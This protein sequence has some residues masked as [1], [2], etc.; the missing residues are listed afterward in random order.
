M[1]MLC[2]PPPPSLPSCSASLCRGQKNVPGVPTSSQQMPRRA[3]HPLG[4]RESSSGSSSACCLLC[5]FAF[6]VLPFFWGEGC[7][8]FSCFF[9]AITECTLSALPIRALLHT[10]NSQ[11]LI[12]GFRQYTRRKRKTGAI[13]FCFKKRGWVGWGGVGW[14]GVGKGLDWMGG[15]RGGEREG[16]GSGQ[17][18]KGRG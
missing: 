11:R 2:L 6:F 3:Q 7:Y 15:G 18:G 1:S 5:L 12:S 13:L 14:G 9:C 4:P 8:F 16:D 10:T 17:R